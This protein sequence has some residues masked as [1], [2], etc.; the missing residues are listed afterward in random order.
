MGLATIAAILE[1]EGYPVTI[2]DANALNLH[3]EQLAP[4]VDDADVVGLTA[5]TPTISMALSIAHHLKLTSHKPTIILGGAHAT[6][7]PEETL[8]STPDID[9]II[10]G[11]GDET[12]I[13]LL[14]TLENRQPLEGVAG[15][16]YRSNGKTV[17]TAT[18]NTIVDMDS[19]PFLA[20]HL[21]PLK[22]Y[23]PYPPHGLASPYAA[24]IT[25]RGC[26]YHCA[27]C[28]K[29][30]FGDKF[31]AQGPERVLAEISYLRERFG[32]RELTFYDDVFTLNKNRAYAIADEMIK[33]DINL[34]W[35]CETRVNLVDKELL[36][37]MKK[38]GC[39]AISYGIESASEEIRNTLQK[40]IAEEQIEE[41]VRLTREAGIHA[42][43]YLMIG[44]PG[45]TP[46][47][48]MS[49][50]ELTKKLKLD[51]AQFAITIPFP[52]TELYKLYLQEGHDTIPWENFV[53]YRTDSPTTPVFESAQL[54]R[55][56]LAYWSGRAQREFYL[57]PSYFWQR[58][59][60]IK[61]LG[62]LKVS[63]KGFLM[64][65]KSINPLAK[66]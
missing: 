58:L 54:S 37:H 36:T 52:G 31:R 53:Y 5:T 44:A 48:I 9:I 65:L 42:I 61:S 11:E 24:V 59:R 63:I 16:S 25:S 1:R 7:L 47:T 43:G 30:V 28:S 56:E 17:S 26:P 66:Q 2:I 34:H 23:R 64:L 22:R 15:I 45:E 10:R 33:K 13:Q 38:A 55:K 62:E 3:P 8:A 41:A 39:Y 19:L 4:M 40:D 14:R 29:P 35:T 60:G 50:V 49:T 12:I 57:R 46:Q 21:L 20:Y 51:F 27:Y 18:G 32:I 6:L